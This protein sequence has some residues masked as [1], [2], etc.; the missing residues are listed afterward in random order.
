MPR[1]WLTVQGERRADGEMTI[2]QAVR[3]AVSRLGPDCKQ[4]SVARDA[5][6][7]PHRLSMLLSGKRRPGRS[8]RKSQQETL[9]RLLMVLR[10]RI[11]SMDAHPGPDQP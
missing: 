6:M 3:M 8:H 4:S 11:V 10:L 2:R 5:G 7:Q 1:K 9:D